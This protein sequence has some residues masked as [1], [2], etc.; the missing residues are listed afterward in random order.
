M[1]APSPRSVL[2]Y[3][4]CET[5]CVELHGECNTVPGH[6]VLTDTV[7]AIESEADAT[8]APRYSVSFSGGAI[9]EAELVT[10]GG[11]CLYFTSPDALRVAAELLTRAVNAAERHGVLPAAYTPEGG[12]R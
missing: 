9:A 8:G 2:A 5:A 4:P 6:F 10:A 7:V 3:T 12:A 1:P 11:A